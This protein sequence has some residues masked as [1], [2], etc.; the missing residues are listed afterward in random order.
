MP[1][2]VTKTK[3]KMLSGY[4]RPVTYGGNT[5]PG[6]A[7]SKILRIEK[8]VNRAELGSGISNETTV[9]V[10][11]YQ[12]NFRIDMRKALEFRIDRL[13]FSILRS[14]IS[15]RLG[16]FIPVEKSEP[17][18]GQ[19]ISALYA[20]NKESKRR[21]KNEIKEKTIGVGSI[22]LKPYINQCN[23]KS[24]DR[25]DE[26]VFGRIRDLTLVRASD[27]NR[28][29]E[30]KRNL[31][32]SDFD[33]DTA[34]GGLN[35]GRADFTN[36]YIQLIQK[37]IDP[38][39][40]FYASN[41]TVS[42]NSGGLI[43]QRKEAARH[44]SDVDLINSIRNIFETNMDSV[45]K[46]SDE[47]TDRDEVLA[48]EADVVDRFKTISFEFSI[49]S[50]QIEDP[51]SDF[52][53]LVSVRDPKSKVTLENLGI[54][55]PHR[56]NVENFYI[57]D[58]LPAVSIFRSSKGVGD[59]A[60]DIKIANIQNEKVENVSIETRLISDDVPLIRSIPILSSY[61]FESFN[62]N[63][64]KNQ[65]DFSIRRIASLTDSQMI[66]ARIYPKTVM[67]VPITNIQNTSL[68]YG[69][70]FNYIFSKLDLDNNVQGVSINYETLGE[71]IAGVTI[72]RKMKDETFYTQINYTNQF[73]IGEEVDSKVSTVNEVFS[74]QSSTSLAGTFNDAISPTPTR[75]SVFTYRKKVHLKNGESCWSASTGIIKNEKILEVVRVKLANVISEEQSS[76]EIFVKFKISGEMLQTNTDLLL[77]TL[78]DA[79]KSEI[80]QDTIR[81]TRSALSD[82]IIF[83]V[84]RTDMETGEV[85][86]VG[87]YRE[88]DFTD[89]SPNLLGRRL[90]YTVKAYLVNPEVVDSYF[91][92]S[93]NYNLSVISE[94]KQVRMPT[95]IQKIQ[96]SVQLLGNSITIGDRAITKGSVTAF[97]N[98]RI[99]K[100]YSGKSMT[101]GTIG[102]ER[103]YS[104]DYSFE[105]YS[106]G[107]VAR[108]Y[109]DN[110]SVSYNIASNPANSISRSSQGYPVIRFNITGKI[111]YVDFLII[112]CRRNGKEK[113]VGSCGFN[114]SGDVTFVDY[115]NRDFVGQV[116]YF[117]TPV[118]ITGNLGQRVSLGS[119][120][121]LRNNPCNTRVRSQA[122]RGR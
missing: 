39:S 95:Y 85:S 52:L 58:F 118:E 11:H 72:Y 111:D 80:F 27:R 92:L 69:K 47:V 23:L 53:F 41:S 15:Q 49:T 74:S 50:R 86:F 24:Q 16:L 5:I 25:S 55:V 19:V 78:R 112:T 54:P 114:Q 38:A 108:A 4:D 44:E 2:L 9:E 14:N 109:V 101:L 32:F 103:S 106:T 120:V 77:E 51:D 57:P 67:D 29:K 30:S 94:P 88:G 76:G 37:K 48:F 82:L 33:S 93:K 98:L 61:R 42:S 100:Y 96:N 31:A 119:M 104:Q 10:F 102:G 12:V 65:D 34:S 71:N 115:S 60:V 84:Q 45:I 56:Q 87:Y 83:G 43:N 17:E 21:R 81:S 40:I 117:A 121:L 97:R 28:R 6:G 26:S 99:Q 63:A 3:T 46:T 105:N 79:N 73:A 110:R 18:P 107:D 116:S 122:I 36:K 22:D 59:T 1:I 89:K 113:I 75:E 8:V 64:I 68:D 35:L 91:E 62:L 66:L 70:E 7:T 13:D 20:G 90:K